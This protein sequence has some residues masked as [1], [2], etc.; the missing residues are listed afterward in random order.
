MLENIQIKKEFKISKLFPQLKIIPS[1][2]KIINQIFSLDLSINEP[3]II[4]NND[5][6]LA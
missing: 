5:N 4:K 3:N 1:D 2:V 6:A